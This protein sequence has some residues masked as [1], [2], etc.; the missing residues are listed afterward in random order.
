MT[1][2]GRTP[3]GARPIVGVFGGTF[4][5]IHLGHLRTALEL[6][7]RLGLREVRF[8]PCGEPPHR[9]APATPA[10]LRLRMVEAAVADEPRFVADPREVEREGPSFTVDTLLDL[11]RDF[12]DATLCLLLGMDA[13]LG[14]PRWHRWRDILDL[15]HVVV[16]H[17]PGWQV[18]RVGT[19]GDLVRERLTSSAGDLAAAPAGRIHVEAVTQLEISATELR[20]AVR[21]GGDPKYLVPEP[22][23][24]IIFETECYAERETQEAKG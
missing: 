2:R 12:P 11:R 21:A 20:A 16:A 13:F 14:L 3:T 18:P 7:E 23:R 4:D 6:H 17:R 8:V 5:P 10:A 9:G 22:V 15:A 19:L 1:E 24:Q